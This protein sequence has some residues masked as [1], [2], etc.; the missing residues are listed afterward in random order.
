MVGPIAV[1]CG[2]RRH[3]S[4]SSCVQC[5]SMALIGGIQM[6]HALRPVAAMVFEHRGVTRYH[7]SL[8]LRRFISPLLAFSYYSLDATTDLPG[9]QT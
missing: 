3:L 9:D 8:C 7:A 5:D 4:R 1:L 6:M 2:H